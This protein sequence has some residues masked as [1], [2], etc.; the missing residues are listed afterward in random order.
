[1]PTRLTS[2]VVDTA[3]LTALPAWWAAALGWGVRGVAPDEVAVEPDDGA[4][5][6]ELTFVAV[7]DGKTVKNRI[8]LDLSTGSASEQGALVDRLV[9]AGAVWVRQAS[10]PWVVLADPEGNEFCVLEP[11]PAEAGTGA[12]AS[13]VM[14]VE[15]PS[16]QARFWSE[17]AGWSV[18]EA[19]PDG[20]RLRAPSGTGPFLDL[21]RVP[22]PKRAKNRIHLDVA[23]MREES[24][25]AAVARLRSAGARPADVGQGPDVTWVVLAD[26]EGQEFC[27]LSPR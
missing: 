10:L 25:D 11:R 5:G 3:N 4:P 7:P 18:V 13:I 8:H 16:R 17:A 19:D 9:E 21:V 12:I 2:V 6:I 15:D 1:L 24:H 20:S 23:P 14:D 27:V 22:E 26:P